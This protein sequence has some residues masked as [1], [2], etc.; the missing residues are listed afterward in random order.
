MAGTRGFGRAAFMAA[1]LALG[2]CGGGGGGD[3]DP[4]A[5]QVPPP[6]P[7]AAKAEGVYVGTSGEQRDIGIAVLVLENDEFWAVYQSAAGVHSGM[8]QGAGVSNNGSY[9]VSSLRDYNFFGGGTDDYALNA[10]YRAGQSIEGTA[11]AQG[12]ASFPISATT[13]AVTGYDYNQPASAAAIAGSWGG[14]FGDGS[15]TGTL[16]V[17]ASGA[18]TGSTSL[19]CQFTGTVAPRP[20]GKNVYDARVTQGNGCGA[21]GTVLAGIGFINTPSAE[22]AELVLML[23]DDSRQ[24]GVTFI[25]ER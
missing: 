11:S 21:P 19:G 2:A 6:P 9:S 3:D 18:A 1:V 25:A 23:V 17:S 22:S 20:S 12:G 13:A 8:L 24:F 5:P 7:A 10:S 16:E 15:E 4:D 14:F